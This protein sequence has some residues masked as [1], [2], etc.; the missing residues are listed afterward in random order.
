VVLN[1]APARLLDPKLATSVDI[2]VVNAVEAEMMCGVVVASP[3]AA[4]EAAARLSS[5]VTNVIVTA[6]GMGLA[7]AQRGQPPQVHAA[8]ALKFPA[9]NGPGR[10][11]DYK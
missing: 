8:H 4:A 2:L 6:G 1:A 5:Q 7:I 11:S 3:A 10:A 9:N